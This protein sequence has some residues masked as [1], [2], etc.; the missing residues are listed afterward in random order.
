MD[1]LDGQDGVLIGNSVNISKTDLLEQSNELSKK[2][3]FTF[4]IGLIPL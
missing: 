2:K 1:T 4:I 3:K